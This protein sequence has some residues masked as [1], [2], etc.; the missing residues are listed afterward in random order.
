LTAPSGEAI[1]S[2]NLDLQPNESDG[3]TWEYRYL[4]FH[5]CSQAASW[6]LQRQSLLHDG[7]RAYDDLHVVCP[8]TKAERDFYFDV[9]RYFGKV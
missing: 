6:K 3:V 1:A 8:P 4:A 9:T 5:P 7:A 2:A